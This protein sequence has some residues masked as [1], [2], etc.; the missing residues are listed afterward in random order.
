MN[1]LSTRE[2]L[3]LGVFVVALIWGGWNYRH[4]VFKPPPPERSKVVTASDAATPAPRVQV[5]SAVVM[6]VAD[7]DPPRWDGDPFYRTWRGGT[8]HAETRRAKPISLNLSAIVVR[9][10][11]RYAVINGRIVRE[12]QTIAGREVLVIEESLVRLDDH[13]V[14]VTLTL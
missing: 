11:S 8:G 9:D 2:R 3:Y 4:L 13:G 7:Y 10:Q 12:G 1:R 14:E 6:A 5:V